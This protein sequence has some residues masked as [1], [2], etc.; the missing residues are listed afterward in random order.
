L[1]GHRDGLALPLAAQRDIVIDATVHEAPF[2]AYRKYRD[3]F[4]AHGVAWRL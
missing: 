3:F 4:D 1:S 2:Q